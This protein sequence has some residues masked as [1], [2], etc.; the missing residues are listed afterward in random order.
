MPTLTFDFPQELLE[1]LRRSPEELA[2]EMRLAMAIRLYAHGEV[3]QGRAAEL[4]GISRA[5]FM[6]ALA[7][8]NVDVV[9]VDVE[10]LRRELARG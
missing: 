1:R 9:Q 2:Q 3:S 8:E 6:D 10:S 5:E 4:A 7:R